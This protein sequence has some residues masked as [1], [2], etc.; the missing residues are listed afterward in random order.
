MVDIRQVDK[1]DVRLSLR[2]PAALAVELRDL[3]AGND[4]AVSRQARAALLVGVKTMRQA[5]AAI[6]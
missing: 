6:R 1:K 2:I 4:V 5:Q 3:A